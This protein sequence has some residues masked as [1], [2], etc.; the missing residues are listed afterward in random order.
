MELSST[1]LH[2][3]NSEMRAVFQALPDLVCRMNTDGLILDCRGGNAADFYLMEEE[4]LVGRSILNIPDKAVKKHF[5]QAIRQ[6]TTHKSMHSFE[7]SIEIKSQKFFFEAR[8]LPLFENQIIAVIRDITE[9]KR[10]EEELRSAKEAAVAATVAKN[11]FLANMSHEIRTPLNAIIGMSELALENELTPELR[12][13][14]Q[15]VS[16]SSEALLA[17]INDILDFSKIEAGKLEIES[18]TFDLEKLVQNVSNIINMRA[19]TK[20]LDLIHTI[21]EDIPN[22]VVAD[23]ARL[24]QVLI[25]LMG[26]AIKFTAKGSVSL[27]VSQSISNENDQA[28]NSNINLH[29]KVIDTG[30]GVSPENQDKI[31]QKFNQADNSTTRKYGGTG[32][33]L[34]ISKSLVELMN[35]NLWIESE[36]GKGST[37]HF[38][39]PVAI[40]DREKFIA[41]QEQEKVVHVIDTPTKTSTNRPHEQAQKTILLV[42]DNPDNQNLAKRILEGGGYNVNIANNGIEAVAACKEFQYDIILM[43]VQMPVMD[44]FEATAKIRKLEASSN[45]NRVPIIA[46]TAHAMQGYR[47]K[48]LQHNMDDY[49]AKPLRKKELFR[50]LE[51][52]LHPIE[53]KH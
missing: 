49:L 41:N 2:Q 37:F 6:L 1:E 28:K 17:V 13:D 11:D 45:G 12:S 15:V 32:L 39:I 19:K 5:A 3:A 42:E 7:Y 30:I 53:I 31:L 16:A 52:W 9:Q 21:E 23:A 36:L 27:K 43:D 25:N 34:S 24:R 38:I 4:V 20:N 22:I 14:L 51:K 33:G 47:E 18:T 26:N 40:G 8:L 29:F 46:L 50:L 35:G 48:C 10:S 44:G